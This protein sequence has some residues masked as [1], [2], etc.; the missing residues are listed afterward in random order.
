MLPSSQLATFFAMRRPKREK[1]LQDTTRNLICSPDKREQMM[2]PL[3]IA[4]FPALGLLSVF[5]FFVISA[6]A[7][8]L[9]ILVNG[10]VTDDASGR[11]LRDALVVVE[12]IRDSALWREYTSAYTDSEGH[13]TL[14][15]PF[16]GRSRILV[17]YDNISSNGVDYLPGLTEIALEPGREYE[18]F[19][20]LL[21]GGSLRFD[22]DSLFFVEDPSP[23]GKL[24]CFRVSPTDERLN[25]TGKLSVYGSR[26]GLSIGLEAGHAVIPAGQPVMIVCD[27]SARISESESVNHSFI[28]NDV[29]RPFILDQGETMDVDLTGRSLEY[30]LGLI[31]GL[32]L[33]I[34]EG[35]RTASMQGFYM[36]EDRS[37]L[38]DAE[39]LLGC[40][41][42][43]L[44]NQSFYECYAYLRQAY[45]AISNIQYRSDVMYATAALAAFALVPFLALTSLAF[46]NMLFEK[47]FPRKVSFLL[48]YAGTSG[49]MSCTFPGFKV[50]ESSFILFDALA[51]AAGCLLL[52]RLSAWWSS[53]RT[54]KSDRM[55]ISISSVLVSTFSMANRNLR[56]RGFRT[57]IAVASL[58]LLVS[59]FIALTSVE[60]GKGFSVL[61]LKGYAIP[62]SEGIL[63]RR[64]PPRNWMPLSDLPISRISLEAIPF[65]PLD[66]SVIS[67]LNSRDEVKLVAAK[68]ES[69]PSL[70]PLFRLAPYGGSESGRSIMTEGAIG[71][72]SA[73]AQVTFI[74]Q[75][76]KEGSFIK[77][78]NDMMISEKTALELGVTPGDMLELDPVFANGDSYRLFSVGLDREGMV[79]KLA[80]TF[81]KTLFE[82]LCDLDG[83]SILP[84]KLSGISQPL[85][86]SL[87][88]CDPNKVVVLPLTSAL[89]LPSM[90]LAR[91]DVLTRNTSDITPLSRVAA[92][93]LGVN[94]WASIDKKI[95]Y[96]HIGEYVEIKGILL[97]VPFVLTL[98]NIFVVM[99][100]SVYER[101]KEI[102]IMTTVGLNPGH[103]SAVFIAEG[104]IVGFIGGA[105]GY[106][107]GLGSFPLMSLFRLD[108]GVSCKTS[109]GW[110]ALALALS[111]STAVFGSIV[112]ALKASLLSTPSLTR[113]W[114]L[115]EVIEKGGKHWGIQLPVSIHPEEREAFTKY[116]LSELRAF[117]NPELSHIFIW[118]LRNI[119]YSEAADGSRRLGFTFVGYHDGSPYRH[120]VAENQILINSSQNTDLRTAYLLYYGTVTPGLSLVKNSTDAHAL[121]SLIR[122]IVI[123]W[124]PLA[125]EDR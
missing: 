115:G 5:P 30:N 118:R 122:K 55:Y 70:G 10:H 17:F 41:R 56:S 37:N 36:S 6:S 95:L 80:G 57:F 125:K 59:C 74:N 4:L 75:I 78:D 9:V 121:S 3:H 119:R 32:V 45:L 62:R 27:F 93:N 81:D 67:W 58:S 82:E 26:H 14:E 86:I 89:K 20:G 33:N 102:F 79:F 51:S 88:Y 106:I 72:S 43:V 64:I 112:P 91:V 50:V 54:E 65:L 107:L 2:R 42:A 60:A 105:L 73:E 68:A 47:E 66:I 84:K 8:G 53:R 104:L 77:A 85:E 25:L 24:F 22:V 35:L 16:S 96:H 7:A 46:A 99:L 38:D 12:R 123:G 108:L 21:A 101:K 31:T 114:R 116:L 23:E 29:G 49:A 90:V 124:D 13:F 34:S 1:A 120:V 87:T 11:P 71:I 109:I 94:S 97:V 117:E 19:F 61:D 111:I 69:Q 103:V 83:A 18:L 76:V 98:G 63:V 39:T 100:N 92:L 113:K 48:I 15:V 28:I 40:A 52:P 44:G 110:G